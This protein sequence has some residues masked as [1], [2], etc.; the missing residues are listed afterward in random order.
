[1]KAFYFVPTFLFLVKLVLPAG[2]GLVSLPFFRLFLGGDT[3]AIRGLKSFL[4]CAHVFISCEIS[5]AN[6]RTF[7]EVYLFCAYSS[8]VILILFLV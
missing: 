7:S 5:V 8:A 2:V 4:F 1:M 3:D 6:G